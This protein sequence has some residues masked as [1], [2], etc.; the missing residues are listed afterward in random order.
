[1]KTIKILCIDDTSLNSSI[2]ENKY[3]I[4]IKVIYEVYDGEEINSYKVDPR[5][6]EMIEKTGDKFD[7]IIIGNNLGAGIE[8]T[9]YVPDNMKEKTII[10]FN[11]PIPQDIIPYKEMGFNYF[12]SRN[13]CNCFY[14]SPNIM[15]SIML[16]I[17]PNKYYSY[18]TDLIPKILGLKPIEK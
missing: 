14:S 3:G 2:I 13:Q 9:K 10:I 7:L 17:N 5:I 11:F 1:M 16:G 6:C 15:I 4:K 8:K 18:Y 12:A